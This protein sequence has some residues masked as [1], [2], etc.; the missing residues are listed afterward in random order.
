MSFKNKASVLYRVFRLDVLGDDG[1]WTVNDRREAGSVS[2]KTDRQNKSGSW[3]V[4]NAALT[5]ALVNGS[6][7]TPRTRSSDLDIDGEDDGVL[8]IDDA[9]SGYPVLQLEYERHHDIEEKPKGLFGSEPR[10]SKENPTGGLST[11][12]T[13]ALVAA[14]AAVVGTIGYFIWKSTQTASQTAAAQ[15]PVVTA[16]VS[17]AQ[18]LPVVTAPSASDGGQVYDPL[19]GGS[20]AIVPAGG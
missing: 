15:L 1:E 18:S 3:D 17:N 11:G 16:P 6:Y 19:L 14:G 2:V 5:R 4:S 12:E 20:G 13:V 10:A 8:F 9:E 7:L